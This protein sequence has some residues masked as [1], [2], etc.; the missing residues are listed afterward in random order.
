MIDPF[1]LWETMMVII[2]SLTHGGKPTDYPTALLLDFSLGFIF[3]FCTVID[4]TYVF[5]RY[6]VLNV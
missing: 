4:V 2:W 1:C 5:F 6:F 3:L